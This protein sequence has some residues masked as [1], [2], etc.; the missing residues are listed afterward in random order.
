MN[1]MF[2]VVC[3]SCFVFSTLLS[4]GSAVNETVNIRAQTVHYFNLFECF[5]HRTHH[6]GSM[7][8]TGHSFLRRGF[9]KAKTGI[10]KFQPAVMTVQ[11]FICSITLECSGQ[12]AT[13]LVRTAYDRPS[14]L[15]CSSRRA[16]SS[17][18]CNAL[19]RRSIAYPFLSFADHTHHID[20]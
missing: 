3:L 10:K 14:T 20:I 11:I 8:C 13:T 18:H 7:T 16:S 17:N 15:G 4:G 1:A 6:T 9:V 5:N 2:V 12:R 19:R